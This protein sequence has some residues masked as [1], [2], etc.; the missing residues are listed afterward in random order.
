MQNDYGQAIQWLANG[1]IWST[2]IGLVAI[3]ML[4]VLADKVMDVFRK[5]KKRKEEEAA[6]SD[7]TIQG[8]LRE[9]NKRL[10]KI[11]EYITESDRKF[12]RDNRRL[13]TLE[14]DMEKMGSGI[15][16][17]AR[18][19]LAHIEH[20]LTGNHTDNLTKARTEI[21]DYLTDR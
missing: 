14:K 20:D 19:S 6:A 16:A 13:N 3:G 2:I 5:R 11:D 9:I 8:Q 21:T 15:N 1:G 18:A 7:T 4:I 10:A 17:I 12:E